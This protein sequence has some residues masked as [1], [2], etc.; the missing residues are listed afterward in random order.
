MNEAILF[1]E[2]R[3]EDADDVVDLVTRTFNAFI[4]PGY[5][6]EGVQ[7][8]LSGMKPERLLQRAQEGD[9]FLV[10]EVKDEIVGT[11]SNCDGLLETDIFDLGNGF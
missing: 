6:S 10:A 5:S 11:V 8:F 1:R 7:H 3:V 2:M 9:L 4:A